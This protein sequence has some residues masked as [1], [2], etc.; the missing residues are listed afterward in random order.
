LGYSV[1]VQSREASD[2]E[3]GDGVERER[4]RCDHVCPLCVCV[5]VRV[6]V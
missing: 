4:G 5:C 3:E 2:E 1:R 6:C